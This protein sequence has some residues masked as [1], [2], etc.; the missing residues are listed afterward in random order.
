MLL[1]LR[2]ASLSPASTN[3]PNKRGNA[4]YCFLKLPQ[5]AFQIAQ[6]VFEPRVLFNFLL[7]FL[8][9]LADTGVPFSLDWRA[10]LLQKLKVFP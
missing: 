9:S 7:E 4:A 6:C 2:R 3:N 8:L 1:R 5:R 10:L